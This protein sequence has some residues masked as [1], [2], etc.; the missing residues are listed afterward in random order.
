MNKITIIRGDDYNMPLTL[1][2]KKT[3]EAYNL[4]G[5]TIYFTVKEKTKIGVENDNTFIIAKDITTH[6][7]EGAGQ[8]MLI[9]ESK[10]T[11]KPAGIYVY[12]MKIKTLGWELHSTNRGDFEIKE[13]VTKRPI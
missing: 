13:N 9:L 2:I 12:D 6:V 10:D 11:S 1:K 5:C 8:S 7:D 4:K 3:D